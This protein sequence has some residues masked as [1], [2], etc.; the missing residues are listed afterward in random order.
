[1]ALDPRA[2][3]PHSVIG[4]SFV[5]VDAAAKVAGQTVF[6]DDLVLPRMV[7]AKL[8]RSPHPHARVL[9]VDVAKAAALPGVVATLV[10]AEL[11]IPFGILPVSQDEHALA[12][13][14]VRFVGDPVAA[15]AA[16]DEETA[17]AALRLV[18]VE[19]EVLPALMTI[20]EALARPDVRIHDY[21]PHGNVH[22]EVSFDFGDV[23]AGF[24]EAYHVREDTFFFEGNTHLPLEQHAAVGAHGPDGKLTLWSSTQTP[25]YV[26]R[27]LAKVLEI[28]AA[29]IRVI[30]CPNGGGFGG[31]SDPFG[32]EIV[33]AKLS[34]KCGRPVKITLTREEVFYCHRGRHPVRMWIKT[35]LKKD[36]AITAMH[37]RSALDGGRL[38]QLRSGEPLLH[39]RPPDRDLQDPALPLRRGA[40]LH[41]QAALRPQARPRHP[42]APLRARVPHRPLLP[43]PRA[44]PRASGAC[45]IPSPLT[46]SPRT[47]CRFG[48]SVSS[49][50]SSRSS[51]R[52]AIARS[53]GAW[54]TAAGSASRAPPT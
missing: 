6:A 48:P 4:T 24:A 36:G 3:L 54:R 14:K 26:H 35:G 34:M 21:G 30:A 49:P 5:K 41:Q 31:K 9:K 53:T 52:A 12:Q 43:R 38:R 28:P 45:A 29:H 33:V 2:G 13:D 47:R 1:M 42:A 16:V 18:D 51:P 20:E 7:F 32:H 25:H 37:F 15:V 40:G 39:G 46:P 23:E 22:K 50:A 44:R 17:E 27:A 8:L 19:Y 10:G 11:P